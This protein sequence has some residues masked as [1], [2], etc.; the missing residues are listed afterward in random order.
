[1]TEWL[2]ILNK[3]TEL[4]S[5]KRKT[6]TKKRERRNCRKKERTNLEERENTWGKRREKKNP[7]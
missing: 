3:I 5:F 4:Q 6:K 2:L 1:M 7:K